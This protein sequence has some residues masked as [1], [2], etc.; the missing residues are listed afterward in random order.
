MTKYILVE[1]TKPKK[2]VKL[3]SPKFAIKQIMCYHC[4]HKTNNPGSH[5]VLVTC[6]NCGWVFDN[7]THTGY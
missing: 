5:Y 3:D 7:P 2:L 6:S 1:E 4:N